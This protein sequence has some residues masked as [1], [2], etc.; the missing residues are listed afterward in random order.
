MEAMQCLLLLAKAHLAAK[1]NLGMLPSAPSPHCPTHLT[2]RPPLQLEAVQC[3]L[4]LA[5]VNLAF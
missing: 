4:L 1:T 5:E 3:L 2:S